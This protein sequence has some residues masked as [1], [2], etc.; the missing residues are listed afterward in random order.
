LFGSTF[1]ISWDENIGF[2]PRKLWDVYETCCAEKLKIFEFF[3]FKKIF[4]IKNFYGIL[5]IIKSRG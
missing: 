3:G 2:V 1:G 4:V 5:K